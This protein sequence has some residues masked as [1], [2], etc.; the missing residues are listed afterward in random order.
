MPF[1]VEAI[2]RLNEAHL[3][4][5]DK[6]HERSHERQMMLLA[7]LIETRNKLGSAAAQAVGPP[8]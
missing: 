3:A 2:V 5:R 6:E 4:A 7:A 1:S 8:R